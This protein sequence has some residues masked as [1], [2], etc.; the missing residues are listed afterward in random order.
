MIILSSFVGVI[1]KYVYTISYQ[2]KYLVV[3]TESPFRFFTQKGSVYV[4][5]IEKYIPP[6]P[7]P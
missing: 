5:D 2:Y 4:V 7:L 3:F 1:I 6:A